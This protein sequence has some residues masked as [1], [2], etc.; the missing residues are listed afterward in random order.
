M[1]A[2]G[3]TVYDLSHIG[4]ARAMVVFD[5]IQRYFRYCGYDM[6]YVRNYTDVD[7]KIINRANA[8][9]VSFDVISERY[10]KE[11]DADMQALGVEPPAHAPRATQH[12]QGMIAMVSTLVARGIAYEI[13][14]DVYFNVGK[15][16][17]YGKLSGKDLDSL[18]SGARVEVDERKHSPLDFALW[19]RSKPGE[20]SWE[21]P[22]GP[23]RPGWHI[24]CSV[25]SQKY[26]GETFDIHAGGMDLVFP[27]HENEIAQ[28]ECTTG[29]EF[30]R[31]WLHNGFVNINKEKMSKSLQNF[32]TIRD[33]LKQYHPETVRLFLL[34]NHYRSPVDFS[35]QNLTEAKAG[36]DRFYALLADL[37]NQ[38][39][40]VAQ[41]PGSDDAAQKA[42]AEIDRFP[43]T[44]RD[45]MDDDFNTA[46]AIGHLHGLTRT[47]NALVDRSKKEPAYRLCGTLARQALQVFSETGAV[48]GLFRESP[49]A[50][51]GA[52]KAG[53]LTALGLTAEAVQ[54]QIA[55]RLKARQDKDWQTADSIRNSLAEKGI[56]LKDGPQGTE[57]TFKDS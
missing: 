43:Q 54:Q 56:L 16:P 37:Q 33:V 17:G 50:Y 49:T 29:R 19:K 39:L 45:A 55:A 9:A 44:F 3:V 1:Y 28:S 46:A 23:G 53:R 13:D 8:E 34:S 35:D 18:L 2:C 6:T 42:L 48:L 22:W 15:C 51:F 12:I 31:Y 57:W 4:H 5:V 40:V 27:H 36:L 25:M 20:P 32:L 52:H 26:L 21:S 41:P 30:A 10:I 24:E 47:L 14:G 11:F 7:D 38:A